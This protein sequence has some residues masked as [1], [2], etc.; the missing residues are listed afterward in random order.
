MIRG[1]LAFVSGTAMSRLPNSQPQTQAQPIPSE[2]AYAIPDVVSF[3][4]SNGPSRSSQQNDLALK[5]GISERRLSDF[6]VRELDLLTLD[7]VPVFRDYLN[8]HPSLAGRVLDVHIGAESRT[9]RNR[10]GGLALVVE[11]DKSQFN[12]L[13]R[14]GLSEFRGEDWPGEMLGVRIAYTFKSPSARL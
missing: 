14:W 10:P 6:T 9:A 2:Q 13:Q 7:I 8:N 3:A 11:L 1:Q 4:I 12:L 5:Y